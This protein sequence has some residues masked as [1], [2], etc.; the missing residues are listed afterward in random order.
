MRFRRMNPVYSR[1]GDMDSDN[2]ISVT[3]GGVTQ[4][5]AVLLGIISIVALYL[6]SIL[7]FSTGIQIPIVTIIIAP[8]VAIV[9]VILAHRNV[10]LAWVFSLVYATME[11]VFLG[12]ISAL[13]AH[14]YGTDVV[15]MALLATF[16]VLAGMLFLYSTG[17]IRVGNFFRR[18]MYSMLIGLVFTTIL[19]III[20]MMGGLG[21]TTGYGLYIAIVIVSVIISSLYLLVDFDS[22][23]NLVEAGAPKEY[24][25]ML[26][27]G[28]VVTIVWL[29]IEL[30][31]FI[32]IIYRKK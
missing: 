16:G 3:Y 30:L 4:K 25:W 8:I 17:L 2:D 31:R 12:F 26:S 14:F 11:G 32:A 6:A 7:D 19:Y 15:M 9:S 1:L 18:A 10:Q 5:T 21:G 20:Y 22:I 23:T 29:Y 27:L 24:E 13:V 28:L